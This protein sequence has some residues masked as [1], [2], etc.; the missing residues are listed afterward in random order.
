MFQW[1]KNVFK[2]RG[3]PHDF[4]PGQSLTIEYKGYDV[5]VNCQKAAVPKGYAPHLVYASITGETTTVRVSKTF[6][7]YRRHEK[8]IESAVKNAYKELKAKESQDGHRL[9]NAVFS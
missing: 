1:I 9:E 3:K 7:F 2:S 5:E 6:K 8:V 4:K